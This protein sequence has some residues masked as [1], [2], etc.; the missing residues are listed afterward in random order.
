MMV[1]FQGIDSVLRRVGDDQY[2][3]TFGALRDQLWLR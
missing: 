1:S 2:V 3:P